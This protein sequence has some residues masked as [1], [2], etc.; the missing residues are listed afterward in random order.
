MV[1]VPDSI[2]IDDP[3]LMACLSS[4]ELAVC[5]IWKIPLLQHYTDHS[6]THSERI[7]K[8]LGR[9]LKKYGSLLN[10]HERFILLSSAYLHDIGMQSPVHAG[11][12]K[13]ERYS[14]EEEKQIRDRHNEASA[15]MIAD[16]GLRLGLENCH[17]IAPLIAQVCKYHRQLDLVELKENSIVGE[18][19]RVPLLAGLLRLGDELDADYQ[20]VIMEVLKTRD[21]PPD[22]KY[23]WWAHHYVRSVD[24]ENE[25]ITLYFEFP[26]KY[27]DSKLID[28]LK[29]KVKNSV[30]DQ[31]LVVYDLF[32]RYGLRLQRDIKCMVDYTEIGLEDIP[33]DLE[34]YITQNAIRLKENSEMISMR[35][36]VDFWIDGVPFSDS[37]QVIICLNKIF[38]HLAEEKILEA[39]KEVERCK[40]FT[41]GPMER[42]AFYTAAGISYYISG[43]TLR[44]RIYFDDALDISRRS[45]LR[46]ISKTESMLAESNALNNIGLVYLNSGDLDNAL[47][48]FQAALTISKE[49]NSRQGEASNLGN[50]GSTYRYK[51][52][53]DQALEYLKSALKICEEIGLKEYKVNALNNIGLVH[54]GIG[55]SD[56]AL[57]YYQNALT[58]SK[59]ISFK[60]GEANALGNIGL[61]YGPKG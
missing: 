10:E 44:S 38:Q 11:L 53:P 43:D 2:K 40:C 26:L 41:M 33:K 27:K 6:I 49:M 39:I 48:Y 61:V 23:H 14:E 45:D 17:R 8:A 35:N 19:V 32:E 31:Y 36:G 58:I 15:K 1:Q 59:E 24:I 9:L 50:I 7:I 47:R 57:E 46:A 22:S 18:R 37:V 20:R 4:I 55:N 51:G 5:D 3:R 34:N 52:D 54:L 16:S 21:I 60:Q 13:K 12:E 25:L 42:I 28:A 56:L 29:G 30:R